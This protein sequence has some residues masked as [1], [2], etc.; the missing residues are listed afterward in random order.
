M[1][2]KYQELPKFIKVF[3]MTFT[4]M[5]L[6]VALQHLG[7]RLPLLQHF[8]MQIN[9]V[10]PLP[11]KNYFLDTVL[12]LLEQKKM[13]FELKNDTS[14]IPQSY[15]A[16]ELDADTANAYTVIDLDTGLILFEK[17]GEKRFAVASL[18]KI[19]TALTALDLAS[20]NEIF[21]IEKR[22]T[23]AI[24]SVIG[25]TEGEKLTLTELLNGA[26]LMSGNDAAEAIRDG[27][28]AKYGELVFIRAMNEKA[29][30]LGLVNSNFSNPQGFD[31]GNNHSSAHDMARLTQYALTQYPLINSIV[32]QDY[33]TIP[34]NANHKEFEMKNWNGLIGVYPGAQGVKIGFTESAGKTTIVVANRNGKNIL[35]VL[36]GA[37]GILERD[38]WAAQLLDL[39]FQKSIG[40]E[41]V[42][43][44]EEQ[45]QIKYASWYN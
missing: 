29:K 11:E 30:F 41:P 7:F 5:F 37:P 22:A 15:A 8:K 32:K 45:L 36:L 27:I 9:L 18:T 1:L 17:N 3:F 23:R 16:G 12:P 14:L 31:Y 33:L 38:L 40:L 26:L 44:T 2:N 25:V 19:M 28:D 21:T 24:P 34:S 42:N 20:P 10:S 43:I 4:S 6:I 39:G 35:V 13:Q